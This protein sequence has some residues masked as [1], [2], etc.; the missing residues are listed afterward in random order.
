MTNPKIIICEGKSV[1]DIIKDYDDILESDWKNDC[2]Y[3]KRPNG[4]IIIGYNRIFSNIKNKKELS[5]LVRLLDE[6]DENVYL[7]VKKQ[8]FLYGQQAIPELEDAW[9]NSFDNTIQQSSLNVIHEIQFENTFLAL[10]QWSHFQFDDLLQGF[11]I[12]SK[13]NY[14]DLDQEKLKKQVA[15]II[16]DVWL[17][18][19]NNLTG[20]EKIKVINHVFFD[21]FQSLN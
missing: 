2:G 13:Y 10:N 5:A 7:Q 12:V 8:I 6:P 17:E 16:K 4:Q 11:L 19:N 20:L 1:F 3:L 14:P 21:L 9:E 15:K 18:L